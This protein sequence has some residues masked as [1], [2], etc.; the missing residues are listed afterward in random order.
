MKS[1]LK[2]I[3]T[4]EEQGFGLI[5][6]YRCYWATHFYSILQCLHYHHL[7]Q[8]HPKNLNNYPLWSLCDL[9]GHCPLNFFD[10]IQTYIKNWGFQYFLVSF[11][12]QK[13]NSNVVSKLIEHIENAYDVE[14]VKTLDRFSFHISGHDSS[15]ESNLS[16]QFSEVFPNQL[17][18]NMFPN[19]NNLIKH[20]DICLILTNS[21]TQ[22]KVGV[23]G[24][25]EGVHGSKQ[26]NASYWAKKNDFCI[27]GIAVVDGPGKIYIDTVESNNITKIIIFIEKQNYIVE[28]YRYVID[29]MKYL[30]LI[31]PDY[32]FRNTDDELDYFFN[33]IKKNW[34][35]PV[36]KLLDDL[37]QY[38]SPEDIIGMNSHRIQIITDITK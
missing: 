31:G 8:Y 3:I 4:T 35:M 9:R 33:K 20:S 36:I 19:L 11:L 5:T 15:I 26:R 18:N 23:F 17:N 1:N 14:F 34:C 6:N 10:N 29:I 37:K 21:Q 22:S 13:L 27:F 7:L 32:T 38:I 30:F 25:I 24:E 2:N 12:N 28:D 16:K